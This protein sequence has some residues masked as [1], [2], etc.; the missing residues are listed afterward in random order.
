MSV[1][2]KNR[3]GR[4]TVL[5]LKKSQGLNSGA[6]ASRLFAAC[7]DRSCK[8]I[9]G[10]EQTYIDFKSNDA[11]SRQFRRGWGPLQHRLVY[12]HIHVK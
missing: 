3:D 7:Y 12:P 11:E 1:V 8:A 4:V 9:I 2:G 10:I 5:N 6:N